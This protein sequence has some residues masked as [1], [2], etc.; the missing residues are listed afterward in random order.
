MMLSWAS[1]RLPLVLGQEEAAAAGTEVQAA[2]TKVAVVVITSVN[3]SS[4]YT[5]RLMKQRWVP[6]VVL[7]RL[8][9]TGF[10]FSH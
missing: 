10:L 8:P 1:R 6:A 9:L 3:V 7:V 2:G 5:L 4:M